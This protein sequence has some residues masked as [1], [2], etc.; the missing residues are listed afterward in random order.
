MN[1]EVTLSPQS[2]EA[3]VYIT[4][5]YHYKNTD[6]A[7]RAMIHYFSKE[8]CGDVIPIMILKKKSANADIRIEVDE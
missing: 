2:L 8:W 1:C 6:I 7:L 5:E 4:K 3:L